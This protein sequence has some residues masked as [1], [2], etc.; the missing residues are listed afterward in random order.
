MHVCNDLVCLVKTKLIFC[1]FICVTCVAWLCGVVSLAVVYS[2]EY[3]HGP[4]GSQRVKGE[5]LD[6]G[7]IEEC[8]RTYTCAQSHLLTGSGPRALGY[9]WVKQDTINTGSRT[10]DRGGK[11]KGEN[12]RTVINSLMWRLLWNR[13]DM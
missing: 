11:G 5:H 9:Q 8:T 13:D 7:G 10:N 4:S 1:E 12:Q 2:Q 6:P 3:C